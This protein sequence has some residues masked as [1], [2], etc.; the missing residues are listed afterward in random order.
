MKSTN[1]F[2][3]TKEAAKRLG[4]YTE[5]HIT[6]LAKGGNLA[7]AYKS[8]GLWK[9]PIDS[10]IGRPTESIAIMPGMNQ[11]P[12]PPAERIKD[13]VLSGI[14]V[15]AAGFC[16]AVSDLHDCLIHPD[17]HPEA[18]HAITPIRKQTSEQLAYIKQAIE[19]LES[20]G[21]PVSGETIKR[22]SGRPGA[23]MERVTE[24]MPQTTKTR[25]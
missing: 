20:L 3:S 1:I 4:G 17:D 13:L 11:Q 19:D 5:R 18:K 25:P 10:I 8:G 21:S 15:E 22:S 9:I 6:R 7:G 14:A 23:N 2:L 12:T 16:E 24:Q